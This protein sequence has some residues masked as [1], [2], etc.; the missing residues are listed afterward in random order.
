MNSPVSASGAPPDWTIQPVDLARR[1]AHRAWFFYLSEESGSLEIAYRVWLLRS[2]GETIL[3][4]TGPPLDEGRRRGLYGIRTVDDALRAQGASV[5]QIDTVILTHLHWDHASSADRFSDAHFYVQRAEVD[6]FLGQA[7]DHPVTARFFSHREMLARL[8]ATDRVHIVDGELQLREGIRLMRV[9]GHTPG[10]QI[11][12]VDRPQGRAVIASDA[13]PLN[14]NY[15]DLVPNGILVN[16][17]DAVAAL[18]TIR[19]LEPAR[20]F[21]GHDVVPSLELRRDKFVD[22]ASDIDII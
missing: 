14:R 3:V 7:H 9:G 21:T 10:T 20:I 11:V 19:S 5:S 2:N 18:R 8:L 1:S 15:V 13:V 4:D 16:V 17:V 6:F 22:G 12:V